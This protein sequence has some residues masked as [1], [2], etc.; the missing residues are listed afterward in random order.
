VGQL[1][2]VSDSSIGAGLRR[3]EAVTGP[4]A[5]RYVEERLDQLD[6]LA[7]RFKVPATE[8]AGRV[9]ALEEQLAAERKRAEQAAREASAGRADD[10]VETAEQLDGVHVVVARVEAESAEA[11]RPMVDRL[12]QRLGSAF[13]TL[14]A[15]I[16]GR[17]MFIAAATDDVVAR[18]LRADEV[19]RA[20]AQLTGGGGG[21]RPQLAQAG[22]RDGSRL[23]EALEAARA[24][25][26]ER[27]G[28]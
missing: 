22:G 23:D 9:A 28:G 3:I 2:I 13:I 6:G 1:Q 18:G 4:E 10:L 25:A 5:D 7:Q 20:A 24:T 21:G 8:V 14:G 15:E 19:V 26:R 11:L 16:D 17:P 12:R 27:L